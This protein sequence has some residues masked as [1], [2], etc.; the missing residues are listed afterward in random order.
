MRHASLLTG[1]LIA[2]CSIPANA[3]EPDIS[4]S[5]KW[6]KTVIDKKF[7]SE[8]VAVADVNKDGKIDIL[9][10][11]FWYEAPDWKPHRIRP[12]DARLEK[13]H[14]DYTDGDKNVYSRSMPSAGPTTST[15]TAG[16]I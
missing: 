14:D 15:V 9:T 5:I 13:G 3:A 1:L 16:R 6:K 2:A 10:G 8:G 12:A 11:E 7:T 4:A